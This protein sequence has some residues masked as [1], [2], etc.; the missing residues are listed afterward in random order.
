MAC[1]AQ[2]SVFVR[3]F[4]MFLLFM[5]TLALGCKSSSRPNSGLKDPAMENECAGRTTA[6]CQNL[7]QC[8]WDST[9]DL[10][11]AVLQCTFHQEEGA[12]KK[13]AGCN[14]EAG[15][16]VKGAMPP[17]AAVDC[18]DYNGNKD[19]CD[20]RA[21]VCRWEQ[22]SE[23]CLNN[24]TSTTSRCQGFDEAACTSNASGC[25]WNV[26][27]DSCQ[28]LVMGQECKDIRVKSECQVFDRCEWK[29]TGC[30]DK[31]MTDAECSVNANAVTC[32]GA[33]CNWTDNRCV[34]R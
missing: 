34:S 23:K 32:I 13:V 22:K 31:Q 9:R 11:Q 20:S 18:T 1:L 19:A 21:G 2:R 26:V 17:S 24:S 27:T 3:S 5:L 8:V 15:A 12:C 6:E 30:I 16:C 33:G 4:Q 7:P 29:G 10:C 25:A 28:D 14:W